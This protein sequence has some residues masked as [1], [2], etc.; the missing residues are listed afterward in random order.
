MAPKILV[1]DDDPS[2]SDMLTLVLETELMRS[3]I[4]GKVGGWETL[5]DNADALGIDAGT[6]GELIDAAAT[7]RGLLDEVHEY[8]RS[9]AFRDDLATFN[10][11]KNPGGEDR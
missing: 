3:A 11:Q 5:R 4:A 7:Q 9:R 10:P 2:I 1:V 8:A 6:F